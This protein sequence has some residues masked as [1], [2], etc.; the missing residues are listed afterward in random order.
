MHGGPHKRPKLAENDLRAPLLP[1]APNGP[2]AH[3]PANN[4]AP[5]VVHVTEGPGRELLEIRVHLPNGF[6][7]EMP[8]GYGS[9]PPPSTPRSR[10]HPYKGWSTTPYPLP[11]YR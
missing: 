7:G 9:R 5:V 2:V 11:P 1:C 3:P 10:R 4:D 6:P 8:S